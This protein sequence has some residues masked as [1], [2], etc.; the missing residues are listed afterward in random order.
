MLKGERLDRP[1]YSFLHTL[2]EGNTAT[3]YLTYHEV[4]ECPIVQ[5]TIS[6]LGMPDVLA[7]EPNL[8]KSI[9]HTRILK[10]WE[11]QWDPDPAR[12]HLDAITFTTE[13]HP[14][15]SVLTALNELDQFGPWRAMQIADDVLV[16]LEVLHEQHHYLHR[17]VKPGNILL[18]GERRRAVLGDL[19]SAARLNPATGGA[20]GHVGSPLYRAPEASTG[21]VTARSDLYAL[22]VTMVEMLNGPFPYEDL[23]RND[24]DRRLAEGRRS[25]ADRY[26]ELAPWV[27]KPLATFVRSL[28]NR[29][30]ERRPADAASALRKL[31]DLRVVDWRRG[32]G[33]GLLG[34]WNG[35]WPGDVPRPR[36]LHLEVSAKDIDRGRNK[37]MVELTARWRRSNGKW[38][39]YAKLKR[40]SDGSPG[41]LAKFFNDVDREAQKAPTV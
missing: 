27:P 2:D 14:G 17:D 16:A 7:R 20:D 30:A 28:S 8:L 12:K 25:L 13:Y 9:E 38:R 18:D 29:D 3:C 34:T 6:T 37:G 33:S 39:H 5:K 32:S 11:A 35:S 24:I 40:R 36:Q 21:L 19:G 31:R 1:T 4:Y 26:F 15:G 23:D 22:G 10:V 41:E